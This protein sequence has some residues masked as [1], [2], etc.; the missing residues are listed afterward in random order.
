[1]T[2][3]DAKQLINKYL[4]IWL[5]VMAFFFFFFF[6]LSA[7]NEETIKITTSQKGRLAMDK[8]PPRPQLHSMPKRM[9][10]LHPVVTPR[11]SHGFIELNL[12]HPS[13]IGGGVRR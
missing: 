6:F 4:L 2:G 3:A 12:L 9:L 1:L 13:P 11:S 5:H 10:R 7:K 8:S